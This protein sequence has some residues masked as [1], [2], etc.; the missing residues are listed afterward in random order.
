M[1]VFISHYRKYEIIKI[2]LNIRTMALFREIVQED[3]PRRG[4]LHLHYFRV[5]F[6][7]NI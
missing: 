2:S 6:C 5:Y 7:L 3:M 1:C 4:P